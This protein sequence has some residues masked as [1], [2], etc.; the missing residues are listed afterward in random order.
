VVTAG[1]VRLGGQAAEMAAVVASA[2][3]HLLNL[4]GERHAD[5]TVVL[6]T[7]P[8]AGLDPH[9]VAEMFVA[10][11]RREGWPQRDMTARH[12]ESLA[13]ATQLP[14]PPANSLPGGI[15]TRPL[16]GGLFWIGRH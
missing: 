14:D 2:A 13:R 6:R 15:R 10:L 16:A 8:L 12:Y 1:L 7:R 4:H 9:L 3:D 11:W 5:G